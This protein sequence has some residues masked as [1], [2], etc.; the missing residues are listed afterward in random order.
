[1]QTINPGHLWL[2]SENEKCCTAQDYAP[3]DTEQGEQDVRFR[4]YE[5]G[6]GGDYRESDPHHAVPDS[7][8]R[9]T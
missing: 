9:G 8:N 7:E 4:R 1:M 3:S 2:T 6:Q 5:T